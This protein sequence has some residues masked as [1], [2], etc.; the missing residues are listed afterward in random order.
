MSTKT[1][2]S[3]TAARKGAASLDWRSWP[4][5]EDSLRA[6]AVIVG[7]LLAAV[8]VGLLSGRALLGLAAAVAIGISMWRFFLPVV[9]EADHHGLSQRI[10]GR[11]RHIPWKAVKRHRVCA[12][13]VLLFSQRDD[14]RMAPLRGI[15][16]PWSQNRRRLLD[17]LDLHLA[18]A[19][20]R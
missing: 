11:H 12:S 14:D 8:L 16:V 18:D 10:L 20:R 19:G 2:N 7:I 4:L 6:A 1:E 3:R 17:L 15:Y 13:G 5:R 9:F